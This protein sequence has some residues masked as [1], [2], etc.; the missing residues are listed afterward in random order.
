MAGA[1]TGLLWLSLS[2]KQHDACRWRLQKIRRGSKTP[3][4]GAM[5]RNSIALAVAGVAVAGLTVLL[6]NHLVSESR[7]RGWPTSS[8]DTVREAIDAFKE[9]GFDPEAAQTEG[10]MRIPQIFLAALPGD[11]PSVKN[12]DRRKAVF[13]AIVLPHVL[14][15]NDRLREDRARLERLRRADQAEKT[16]RSRDRRWLAQMANIYRTR[17][18]EFD[19]LLRRVDVVPPRLAIAQA[20]Q[21]SGWGTSRFAR[22]GNALFGQHAPVGAGAIRARGDSAVAMKAFDTIHRSVLDYMRNLNSHNA[23]REFREARARMRRAGGP[24]DGM[25][26]AESLGRYSEEGVLYVARLKSVMRLPEVAVARG[27]RL[28]EEE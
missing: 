28:A 9:E 20:V 2:A 22:I 15:A 19:E 14:R 5:S 8:A 12:V 27:A 17:P 13:V 1:E 21:E 11:L 18:M 10:S 26:L 24:M 25:I 7:S 6:A 3:G 16:L 23:Y 4:K